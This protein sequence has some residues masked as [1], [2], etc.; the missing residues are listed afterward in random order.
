MNKQGKGW[1]EADYIA[2]VRQGIS[3]P[4]DINATMHQLRILWA[5]STF[6]FGDKSLL[7][8][9]LALL[10][11]QINHHCITFEAMQTNDDQFITKL[12]CQI[13]TRIFRWLQQCESTDDRD[14]VDDDI[15][16]FKPI[17]TQILNAQFIQILPST[18]KKK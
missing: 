6:F 13:D 14:K 1:D 17:V 2:A 5:L 3:T 9:E 10:I 12:G 16:N 7:P 15:A 18:F 8:N 4:D 11:E